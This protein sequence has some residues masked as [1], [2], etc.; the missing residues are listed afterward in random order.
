M[1]FFYGYG[2]RKLIRSEKI[3]IK[4]YP[5]DFRVSIKSVRL[6][7][8]ISLEKVSDL[9]GMLY[10][11]SDSVLVFTV[12]SVQHEKVVYDDRV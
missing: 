2:I 1:P 7:C 10:E 4:G 9:D 6:W 11:R 8:I 5:T 12:C 3:P